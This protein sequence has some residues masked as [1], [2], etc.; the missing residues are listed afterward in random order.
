MKSL[1]AA[2]LLLALVSPVFAYGDHVDLDCGD[3]IEVSV[4]RKTVTVALPQDKP[5]TLRRSPSG[6]LSVNGKTCVVHTDEM[7]FKRKC[8]KGDKAACE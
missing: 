3:D 5:F 4:W 7:Y 6:K 8:R 1:I 2:A